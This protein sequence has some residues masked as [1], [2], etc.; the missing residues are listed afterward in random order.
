MAPSRDESL[1][2]LGLVEAYARI[3]DWYT[4][5]GDEIPA[6]DPSYGQR[7]AAL[8]RALPPPGE[9]SDLEIR[10][11]FEEVLAGLLEWGYVRSDGRF[12]MGAYAKGALRRGGHPE[13]LSTTDREKLTQSPLWPVL[14]HAHP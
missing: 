1:P 11:V 3:R 12:E 9:I 2:E 13:W 5:H 8:I 14:G 7:A 10:A 4:R 6:H